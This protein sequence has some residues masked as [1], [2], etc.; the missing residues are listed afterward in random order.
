MYKTT[1][2]IIIITSAIV[3]VS[4]GCMMI[5]PVATVMAKKHHSKGNS[6]ERGAIDAFRD[7]NGLNGHGYDDSCPSGHSSAFC[8]N[9]K[10][11][12][13]NQFDSGED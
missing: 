7:S 8:S 12:Y 11:A 13:Q 6:L 5:G 4:I 9:Y 2:T 1:T 10:H 3:L